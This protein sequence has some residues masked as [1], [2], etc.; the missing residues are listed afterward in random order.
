[1]AG[2]LLLCSTNSSC[3]AG[4]QRVEP[5]PGVELPRRQQAQVWQ[6]ARAV[7]LH[8]LIVTSDSISGVPYFQPPSCDSCRVSIP[9]TAVDSVRFGDPE[10]A[11]PA[12]FI[13]VALVVL[14]VYAY[15]RCGLVY[16]GGT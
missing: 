10:G 14:L 15:V 4:W 13:G 11:A 16:C 6:G 2:V 8:G 7:R 5:P 3:G 1:M 9:R 12:S